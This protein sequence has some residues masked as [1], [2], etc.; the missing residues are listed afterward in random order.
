MRQ[1]RSL[2]DILLL[3]LISVDASRPTQ[4]PRHGRKVASAI[5][6][7]ILVFLLALRLHVCIW[8]CEVGTTP[9]PRA[10]T[11]LVLGL[12]SVL[13]ALL[14]SA[15]SVLSGSDNVIALV[16]QIRRLTC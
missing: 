15:H 6:G 7:D 2:S 8:R 9:L 11:H 4:L 1:S 10:L 13:I 16:V 3:V 5:R 14:T 12:D